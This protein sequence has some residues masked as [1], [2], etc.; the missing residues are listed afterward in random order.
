MSACSHN[1]ITVSTLRVK[2]NFTNLNFG[3]LGNYII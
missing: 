3:Q 2:M 1:D